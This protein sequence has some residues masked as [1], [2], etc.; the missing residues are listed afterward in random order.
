M[1]AVMKNL[2]NRINSFFNVVGRIPN[3]LI[4]PY[5]DISQ[6][7]ILSKQR[8]MADVKKQVFSH[9]NVRVIIPTLNERENI[10]E[11]IYR[12]RKMGFCDILVVDGHSSDG[13]AECAQNLGARVLLQNGHGKG[14]AVRDAFTESLSNAR[15]E[16]IVMM[17]A[18]GSMSP[19]ELPSFIDAINAGADIVKGSR[20]LPQG[21]SDDLTLT[22]RVG[23]KMLTMVINFLFLTDYTDLCYGYIAFSRNALLQLSS[24]LS[25][26]EFEIETEICVK[27]NTLGLNIVEIPSFERLRRFGSSNLHAFRDGIT[28]FTLLLKEYFQG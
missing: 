12:L 27:A 7:S 15:A 28:I 4:I 21:G 11:I 16:I 25:G 24:C 2:V 5:K 1:R 20:F 22:R 10:H 17:D 26:K 23:N 3:R 19:E 9:S 13:T 18:D 8:K 6:T 14:A